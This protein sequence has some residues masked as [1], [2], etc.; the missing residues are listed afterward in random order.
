MPRRIACWLAFAA[1][2]GGVLWVGWTSPAGHPA[3][4]LTRV[5]VVVATAILAVAPW[6]A[7]R[8]FGPVGPGRLAQLIR[9][10][11][12]AAVLALLVAKAAVERRASAGAGS[13]AGVAGAWTG[14]IVF[15][16][17]LAGYTAGLLAVTA[18]R[19]PA[20]RAALAIGTAAGVVAGLVSYALPPVHPLRVP[21]GWL[22]DVYLA[23]RLLAVPLLLGAGVAAGLTAARR[24]PATRRGRLSVADN[25]SRQGFAAGLCAGGAAALLFVLLST[26]TI[27]LAPHVL[28]PLRWTFA[29]AAGRNNGTYPVL[30]RFETGA[31]NTAAGYLIALIIFPVIFAGLGAWG[32]MYG[33]D[34]PGQR[35]GGGGGGGGGGGPRRPEPPPP[36]GGGRHQDDKLPAILRG[37]YL[38]ELPPVPG[39]SP[40][41]GPGRRV[42][43]GAPDQPDRDRPA[44]ASTPG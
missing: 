28:E 20:G 29:T 33:A 36:D 12:Y 27:V 24:T 39:L 1:A 5:D 30:D 23:G 26:G 34:R 19:P 35:P 9:A 11:G 22:A 15:L 6:P 10:A 16:I 41:P 4:V 44:P 8:R 43:A 2:A 14:E 13:H 25:R 40:A 32:G 31:A 38:K 18:R 17:V 21:A 37:G 7:R 3:T 42:P